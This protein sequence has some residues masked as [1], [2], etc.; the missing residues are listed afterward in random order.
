MNRLEKEREKSRKEPPHKP[1][2]EGRREDWFYKILIAGIVGIL[3]VLIIA[4][5]SK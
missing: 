3:I 1:E 4:V 2:K 5:Y